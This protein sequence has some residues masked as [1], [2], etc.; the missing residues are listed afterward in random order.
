MPS[1]P[2]DHRPAI[3][4]TTREQLDFLRIIQHETT[5]TGRRILDR[6]AQPN[7]AHPHAERALTETF[8]L[9]WRTPP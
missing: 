9:L 1:S 6:W 2:G 8:K 5:E 4:L 7:N 3:R